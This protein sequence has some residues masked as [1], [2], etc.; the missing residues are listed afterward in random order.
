MNH[1]QTIAAVSTPPGQ[2][3]IAVIRVSG[4]DAKSVIGKVFEP[5]GPARAFKDR[6]MLYGRVRRGTGVLDRA[7]AVFLKGPATYTGEDTAEIHCHGGG[8]VARAVLSA[9]LD[10]GAMPAAPGE[11]TRR[12]F[13]NG[14]MDLVQAEAVAGLIRADTERYYRMALAQLS[15]ALSDRFRALKNEIVG[16]L[17]LAEANIDFAEEDVSVF[18][19]RAAA[20]GVRAIIRRMDGM[21]LSYRRGRL[22]S[23]GIRVAIVGPPNAGKSSLFNALCEKERVIVDEHPGTTRDLVEETIAVAGQKITLIDTAGMRRSGSRVES[24]GIALAAR[25]A[26]QADITLVVLDGS[27]RTPRRTLE[28]FEALAAP[29]KRFVLNK[30]DLPQKTS[31]KKA[32]RTSAKKMTGIRALKGRILRTF[33][34]DASEGA[35]EALSSERQVRSLRAARNALGQCLSILAS[36]PAEELLAVELRSAVSHLGSITGEV[37]DDDVLNRIFENFCIGK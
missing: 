28:M 11:F 9:V 4:P 26:G 1:R 7:M 24:K 15:G 27:I 20:A 10:A 29:G 23:H 37:T 36:G 21:L 32:L 25:A 13:L 18:D 16:L 3:G 12:A 19:P 5:A 31:M 6:R 2:G 35:N 8:F 17:T 34:L 30:A 22:I 33:N 14:K